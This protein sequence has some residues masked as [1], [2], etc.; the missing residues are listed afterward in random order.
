L[1]WSSALGLVVILLWLNDNPIHGG[2]LDTVVLAIL[3][4][5]LA[6]VG[7]QAGAA[8]PRTEARPR[9]AEPHD[10]SSGAA[11]YGR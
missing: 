9:L 5:A 10:E 3:A 1:A 4:G 6:A 2:Q 8:P 11:S 7:R